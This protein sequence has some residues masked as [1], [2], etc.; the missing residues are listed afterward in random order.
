M[1]LAAIGIYGVMAYSVSQRKQEIAIRLALG[2]QLAAVRRMV[3]RQ[4][5]LLA[6]AGTVIGLAASLGLARFMADFLFQ[7]GQR[8]PAVFTAVPV[9][10][11]LVALAAVWIPA[12]RASGVDPVKALQGN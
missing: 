10:L 6:L 1:L 9:V 5:M 3:I 7:T 2:A 11:L 12:A 4:G 8:D